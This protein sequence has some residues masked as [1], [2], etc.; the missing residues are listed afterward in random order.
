MEDNEPMT[1]D[2]MQRFLNLMKDDGKAELE[3]YRML[4][5]ILG[6]IFPQSNDK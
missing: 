1:R 6:I 2:E 3:A 4:A 5:Y